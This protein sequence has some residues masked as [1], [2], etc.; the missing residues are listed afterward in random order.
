MSAPKRPRMPASL[1][2]GMAAKALGRE[3][4]ARLEEAAVNGGRLSKKK[5]KCAADNGGVGAASRERG[6]AWGGGTDSFHGG[7]LRLAE[8]P[9]KESDKERGPRFGGGFDGVFKSGGGAAKRGKGG[10]GGGGKSGGAKRKGGERGGGG[11]KGGKSKGGGGGK[12]GKRH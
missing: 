11:G 7:M 4:T 3:E 12:G 1:G 8:A 5:A 9:P 2:F 6:V 10:K